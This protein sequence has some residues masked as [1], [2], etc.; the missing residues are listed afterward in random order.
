[1]FLLGTAEVFADTTTSTLLPMLVEKRDLGIG[2][3][4]IMAGF[5]TVNQMVGPPIGAA[6]FAPGWRSRS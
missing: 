2:N 3:A 4:R 5:I 1:M 6:L